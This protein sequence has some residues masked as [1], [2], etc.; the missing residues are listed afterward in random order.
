[1]RLEIAHNAIAGGLDIAFE[2]FAR[3][4]R[5]NAA[6]WDILGDYGSGGD[7]AVVSHG[8]SGQDNAACSQEA[9][10]ADVGADM[11][12]FDEIVGE[13]VHAGGDD[14]VVANVDAPRVGEVEIG[15]AR[16][17]H[18]LPNGH[19]PH[20]PEPCAGD[21]LTGDVQL[22]ANFGEHMCGPLAA[23]S[24]S[25]ACRT[26]RRRTCQYGSPHARGNGLPG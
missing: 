8:Y 14:G 3:I 10:G 26:N 18:A 7:D 15:L 6:R 22:G 19:A 21:P 1:M 25:A 4:A 12:A 9:V 11:D 17:A 24:R 20:A 13:D 2:D 16:D 5:N 23:L